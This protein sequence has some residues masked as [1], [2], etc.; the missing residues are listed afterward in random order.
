LL[1]SACRSRRILDKF[2]EEFMDLRKRIERLERQTGVRAT[3]WEE[4]TFRK[5]RTMSSFSIA[6]AVRQQI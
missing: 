2:V 3:Q 1:S 4:Y 6:T 5:S